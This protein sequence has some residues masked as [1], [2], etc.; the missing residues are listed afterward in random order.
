MRARLP[1]V[2]VILAIVVWPARAAS[3]SIEPKHFDVS[4][5]NAAEHSLEVLVERCGAQ[6]NCTFWVRTPDRVSAGA[7]IVEGIGEG[8]HLMVPVAFQNL[9]A[10]PCEPS[11]GPRDAFTCS[12]FYGVYFSVPTSMMQHAVLRLEVQVGDNRLTTEVFELTDLSLW[13]APN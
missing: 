8:G 10:Y 2:V 9:S 11:G 7:L 1:L 3:V 5:S 13:V 4:P 6:P 12:G